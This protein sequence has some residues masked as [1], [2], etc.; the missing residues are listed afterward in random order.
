MFGP[1][2]ITLRL[3]SVFISHQFTTPGSKMPRVLLFN[4]LRMRALHASLVYIQLCMGCVVALVM[5]AVQQEKQPKQIMKT[6]KGF[7]VV[8]FPSIH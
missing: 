8:A 1:A 7:P 6:G 5:K 2:L 4:V 3:F